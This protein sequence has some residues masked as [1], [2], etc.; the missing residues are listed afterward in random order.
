MEILVLKF[1]F[2]WV[3]KYSQMIISN[4]IVATGSWLIYS[5]IDYMNGKFSDELYHSS[6]KVLL[7]GHKQ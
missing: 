5:F 6:Y 2:P 1:A 3:K 7:I 4:E